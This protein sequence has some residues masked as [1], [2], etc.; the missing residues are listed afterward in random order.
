MKKNIMI[1]TTVLTML[2]VCLS[3][4]QMVQCPDPSEN[5]PI[6][7][8]CIIIDPGKYL[9]KITIIKGI[10]GTNQ[11]RTWIQ[12]PP[13]YFGGVPSQLNINITEEVNTSMLVP[14]KEYYFTGII[15]ELYNE[16]E[17]TDYIMEVTKIQP[18]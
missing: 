18:V 1:G 13:I 12:S 7:A 5:K 11:N 15:K 16:Q 3:G 2:I 17:G 9:N 6:N 10:F 4:C 8:G 14:W